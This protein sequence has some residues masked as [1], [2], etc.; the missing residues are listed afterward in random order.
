[1]TNP[2]E[3]MRSNDMTLLIM[4]AALDAIICMDREGVITLWTKQAEKIFGW[5]EEEVKG[6]P[7]SEIIIPARYRERHKEGLKRY[8]ETG[9][10][11]VLNKV[12]EIEGLNCDGK[13]FP[14]ELTITPIKQNTGEFFCAFLRDISERKTVEEELRKSEMRYRSLIEQAS[15]AIMI[16]DFK[17]NFLDVNQS[18]CRMFGYSKPELLQM[19][20]AA[21]IDPEEL[22][23]RPM[24]FDRLAA[25][26]HVFSERRMMHRNGNIIDVE[27]NVKQVDDR[28]VL[29]I[30]RDVTVRKKVQMELEKSHEQ[31]R[32]LSS[33]LET[34]RE[35]ERTSI[36]REI[37]DELGQQ[38]TG[39]KMDAAWL[40]KKI[41]LK[42]KKVHK[43]ISGMISLIDKTMTTVRHISSELRP[44][45]LDDLGLVDAMDWQSNEF[46]MRTGI[47]CRFK[48]QLKKRKFEK[49]L[50][51]GIFRVYQETLTNVA[52]HAEAT[53]INTS[54]V[55][56]NGN[57][58]LKV[59]DNGK[60]FD[61]AEIK[62][63]NT[64]GLLGMQ[65]RAM[66]FGGKI[67]IKSQKGKG[68]VVTLQVPRKAAS[69][70]I[71]QP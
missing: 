70:K 55:A 57:I 21:L 29:A 30:A 63:K 23:V 24:A 35:D 71:I 48:P 40:N 5:K 6:K 3:M 64:L 58:I 37:H 27:A 25:G 56:D 18:L 50:S 20:I 32:K 7:L 52:R 26:L 60:G 67:I 47:R 62:N 2:T 38:L 43:K 53:K 36:A 13:E 9:E 65:E 28:R 66:M 61:E 46:E 42:D 31:L 45:I 54:L 17:G 68:T 33:H 11:N 59:E 69:G 39:L 41:P 44:R 22:K 4:D 34:V 1:M 8:L 15:D 10:N 51:T 16:T 12:I 49:N 14:I 19:N